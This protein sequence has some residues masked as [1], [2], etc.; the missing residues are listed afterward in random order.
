MKGQSRNRSDT[1]AGVEACGE[2]SESRQRSKVQGNSEHGETPGKRM[3]MSVWQNK[4]S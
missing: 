2:G 1:Q 4:T 3:E